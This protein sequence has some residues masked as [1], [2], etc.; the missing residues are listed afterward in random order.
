ME[1]FSYSSESIKSIEDM[2]ST[3]LS[4]TFSNV[5]STPLILTLLPQVYPST[6]PFI[7]LGEPSTS[8]MNVTQS[9]STPSSVFVLLL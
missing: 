9:P 6:V 5:L 1:I 2:W 7:C 3:Y 8:I 4:L